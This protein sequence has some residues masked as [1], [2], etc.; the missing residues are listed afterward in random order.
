MRLNGLIFLELELMK[1]VLI[2]GLGN[3]GKQYARNRHNVGLI[4]LQQ[5][6]RHYQVEFKLKANLAGHVAEISDQMILYWPESF[7]NLIGKNVK[8]ATS[9]FK[10]SSPYSNLIVLH[11]C[12]ETKPGIVKILPPGISFRGHNGL[13]SIS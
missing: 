12:L 6:A 11:D 8:L 7:M 1:K 5:M 10:V 9:K 13:K 3:T 4:C 2:V